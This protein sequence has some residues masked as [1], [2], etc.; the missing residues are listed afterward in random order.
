MTAWPRQASWGEWL[1]HLAGL[2]Q[3]ALRWPASIL[4]TL[5][6]LEPMDAVGPVGL[7]EVYGVLEERLRFFRRDPDPRRYGAVFVCS[8]EEARGRHFPVVFLPGLAEGMFPRRAVGESAAA[9]PIP[10]GAASMSLK[11]QDDRAA[12]ERRLLLTALAAADRQLVVSYPSMD[13]ALSRPRVPSFYALE[14]LRAVEGKLPDLAAFQKRS[15]GA[16]QTRLSWP[17]PADP[18]VAVDNAEYDLASLKL[19]LEGGAQ[20]GAARYLVDVSENLKRSLRAR[21]RRWRAGWF[22]EDGLVHLDEGCSRGARKASPARPAPIRRRLCRTS[23]S[24]R[25][26]SPCSRFMACVR[27]RMRWRWIRWIR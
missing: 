16:A 26:G 18:R 8:I 27:G 21:G 22:S 12:D 25:T 13:T 1:E 7:E 4:S 2:A 11:L 3:A 20:K 6:D 9:G 5:T 14:I 24:V 15:A 19:T 23:R 10:G 17:A